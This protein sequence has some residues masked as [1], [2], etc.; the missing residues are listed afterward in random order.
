MYADFELLVQSDR[1]SP[2]FV[3]TDFVNKHHFYTTY[4]RAKWSNFHLKKC[5]V[6]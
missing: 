4:I 1:V 2:L 3:H 6:Y 5:C